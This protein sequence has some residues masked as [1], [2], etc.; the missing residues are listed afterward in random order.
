MKHLFKI[1]IILIFGVSLVNANGKK[2]EK[3]K[4]FHKEYNVSSSAS[5]DITNMYGDINIISWDGSKI[6]IDVVVTVKSKEEEYAERKMNSISIVSSGNRDKVKVFTK[7][8]NSSSS[9]SWFKCSD[10]YS[11]SIEYTVKVPKTNNLNISNE[12]G[13]IFINKTTGNTNIHCEYGDIRL[14]S[15]EGY[16][17]IISLEYSSNSVIGF[18][19]KGVLNLEYSKLNL[20]EANDLTLRCN[21]SNVEMVEIKK[22][23]F[24]LEYGS[25]KLEKCST[26]KGSGEYMDVVIDE[27]YNSL[28]IVM[29]YGN[30]KIKKL[31]EDF[32]LVKVHSEFTDIK[33]GVNELNSFNFDIDLSYANFIYSK[34]ENIFN[35]EKTYIDSEDK[36]YKGY[37][38]TRTDKSYIKI[39]SQYGSVKMKNIK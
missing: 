23:D 16:S 17:N 6:I 3:K 4:T 15:L 9:W 37:F 34:N 12:Y 38:N 20:S 39:S 33:I 1:A 26:L 24:K 28:E 10:S 13:H 30:F 36:R 31:S 5:L 22:I 29:E 19:N 8:K 27:L 18:I 35:I 14:G 11:I 7:F 21:Y 25:V 32:R 2:H